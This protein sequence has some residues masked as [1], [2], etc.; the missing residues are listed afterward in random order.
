MALAAVLF[1]CLDPVQHTAT[2]WVTEG[3]PGTLTP[4]MNSLRGPKTPHK[5]PLVVVAFLLLVSIVTI[6]YPGLSMV[7]SFDEVVQ[8]NPF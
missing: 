7:H 2:S 6:S 3:T 4:T 8:S 1:L 5:S